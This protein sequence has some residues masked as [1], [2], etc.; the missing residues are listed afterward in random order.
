MMPSFPYLMAISVKRMTTES[1]LSV[2][3]RLAKVPDHLEL[4]ALT[5][6]PPCWRMSQGLCRRIRT[7]SHR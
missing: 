2:A 4:G 6:P 5:L 7:G 3:E 1:E